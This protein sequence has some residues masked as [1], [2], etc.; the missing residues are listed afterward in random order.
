MPGA[1]HSTAA[2]K[3]AAPYPIVLRSYEAVAATS[4]SD[5]DASTRYLAFRRWSSERPGG[6]NL[7]PCVMRV[8]VSAARTLGMG[9]GDRFG[10]FRG[11]SGSFKG[12][13]QRA[14]KPGGMQGKRASK[15]RSHIT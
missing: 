1:P 13:V 12:R 2:E 5:C 4:M 11:G 9:F 3:A 14:D 10:D 7:T 6:L 15:R 8:S